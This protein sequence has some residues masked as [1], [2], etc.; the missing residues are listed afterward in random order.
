MTKEIDRKQVLWADD[1]IDL[2]RPHAIFLNERGYEVTPVTNGDDAISLIQK[3]GFDIVLL[4]EMMAGRDGL[5]T[6]SEIKN[7]NPDIPV[8]MITKNEEERL[9]E[10]A[11]GQRIDDYLTKPVNPSQILSACKKLLDARQILK[12]RMGLDYVA[13][14]NRMREMMAT[15][16]SFG[17]WTEL[18]VKLSE[19]DNELDRYFDAGLRKMHEDLR[20]VCNQEFANFVEAN[21]GRW[22]Q[23]EED[24]PTLSVDVVSEYVLPAVQKGEQVFF[25]VV[26]C[27]RLDHWLAISPLLSELFQVDQQYH[28]SILPT[29]TPYSRNA[30]FSGLFPVD[31]AQLYP[32]EWQTAR[33]DENSKN[34]HEHQ[35]LDRQLDEMD[36]TLKLETR[37]V[38]VLDIAEGNNLVKKVHTYRSFP[39]MS[40]VFNFLDIL[41]HGRSESDILKEMAPNES[42]YRS[43]TRSWFSHS[44]LFEMLRKLAETDTTIVLTT[45][46]G[47]VLSDRATV[48]HGNRDTSTNLRY[49]YGKNLRCDSRHAVHV[50]DPEV[51]GLPS[52]GLGT[53]YIITKEDHYFVYPT[54]F[55]EYQRLYANSFQHG[56]ISMEEMILP[57]AILKGR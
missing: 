46:H 37:Y 32:E 9:M 36:P 49:K 54:K 56:G 14:S 19:W 35:L 45:D 4:D 11:L 42:A 7:I 44:S 25:V 55:N 33:D 48:A 40:V 20:K 50:K 47:C 16:N 28:Y 29:A 31:I 26:D 2:L 8:I 21:Y 30:I 15:A 1:E 13:A 22:V 38:K 43:L 27:L 23:D 24:S 39:L 12:D 52:I 18:H 51:Y 34:R 17:D 3:Q 53:N 57:V 10:E 5:S 41:T 6:L